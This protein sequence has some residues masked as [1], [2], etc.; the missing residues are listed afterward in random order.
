RFSALLVHVADDPLLLGAATALLPC[1]ALYSAILGAAAL[2][3]AGHGSMFMASFALVT[4]PALLGGAQL[5]R[6]AQL[7]ERGRRALG[8][9]LVA[10]ALLTALRPLST[11]SAEPTAS[12]PLH[13]HHK[14][15]P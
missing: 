1:G 8:A 3:T 12:C 15:S 11:L 14:E 9:L 4:T 5:A 13:A 6:L 10:G 7:G 2:G